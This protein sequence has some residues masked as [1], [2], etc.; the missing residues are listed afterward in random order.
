MES[1]NRGLIIRTGSTSHRSVRLLSVASD[2]PTVPSRVI[3]LS[4]APELAWQPR[5][6]LPCAGNSPAGASPPKRCAPSCSWMA[7]CLLV[8][9]DRP[10]LWLNAARGPSTPSFDHVV[11]GSEQRGRNF[12]AERLC[13]LDVDNQLE[14][15]R[16]FD[17]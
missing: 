3:A 10:A 14:L 7:R 9:L 15:G 6:P 4:Q 16:P 5:P 2:R 12:Y 13:G 11:G 1:A 8:L 17:R